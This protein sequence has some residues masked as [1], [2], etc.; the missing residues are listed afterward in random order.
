MDTTKFFENKTFT[1]RLKKFERKEKILKFMYEIKEK[2]PEY[3]IETF[4]CILVKI[5]G[6]SISCITYSSALYKRSVEIWNDYIYH[7]CNCD[8]SLLISYENIC[9]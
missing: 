2:N 5:K 9:F 3:N 8:F 6:P 1:E 4:I 7:Y